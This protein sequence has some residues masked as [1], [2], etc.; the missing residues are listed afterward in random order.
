MFYDTLKC[1]FITPIGKPDTETRRHANHVE[2]HIIRYALL[3]LGFDVETNLYRADKMICENKY[4]SMIDHLR[5]DHLCITDI[6]GLNANVMFEYGFRKATGLPMIVLAST[7]DP[8]Q[9]KLLP[10]DISTDSI[11]RYDL[12]DP[13]SISDAKKELMSFA[14]TY[15]QSYMEKN[16]V[17]C[18]LGG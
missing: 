5:N 9:D 18:S 3:E 12:T 16:G 6:T 2:E 7:V 8:P 11:I 15:I 1:F 4:T 17:F 10:F 14:R 13:D